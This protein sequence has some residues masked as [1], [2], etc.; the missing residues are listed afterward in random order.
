[1]NAANESVASGVFFI[2]MT[3]DKFNAVRK[4]M[5]MK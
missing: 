4:V 5:M 2:R 3:S 1:L